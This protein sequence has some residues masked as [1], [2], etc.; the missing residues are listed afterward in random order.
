L[1]NAK[2]ALEKKIKE[3]LK[4]FLITAMDIELSS[5][6]INASLG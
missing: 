1:S 2:L 3:S 6:Y 4:Y 5:E